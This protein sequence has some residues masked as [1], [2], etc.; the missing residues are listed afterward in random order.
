[1]IPR[2]THCGVVDTPTPKPNTDAADSINGNGITETIVKCSGFGLMVSLKCRECRFL[3]E[4]KKHWNIPNTRSINQF[5]CH[6]DGFKYFEALT[7][8]AKV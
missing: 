3:G 8:T 5:E 7:K 1:M 6:D 4:Y 2:C